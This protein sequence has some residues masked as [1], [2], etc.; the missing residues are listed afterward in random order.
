MLVAYSLYRERHLA[1]ETSS[2]EMETDMAVER[3]LT[4]TSLLAP[5]V[6]CSGELV[7]V[8]DRVVEVVVDGVSAGRLEDVMSTP[9]DT[10]LDDSSPPVTEGVE[11]T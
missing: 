8:V 1:N 6:V 3:H 9:P 4:M 5:A 2:T 11:V 7:V 10:G